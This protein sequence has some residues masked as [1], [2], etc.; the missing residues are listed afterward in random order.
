MIH[1]FTIATRAYNMTAFFV[2]MLAVNSDGE[3]FMNE[4]PFEPYITDARMNSRGNVA[5][6]VFDADYPTYLQSQFPDSYQDMLE[7]IPDELQER[8]DDGEVFRADT[9]EEL[10]GMIG[11]PADALARTAEK[12]NEMYEQGADTQFGVVPRMLCQVKTAPFYAVPIHA[13]C[14]AM[15]FG[16]Y[17][18]EDSQVCTDDEPIAG[19][20]AAGNCQGDF[21]AFNY[22]VHCPGCS[23]GRSLV[24]GQLIGEALA[25]GQ[26]ITQLVASR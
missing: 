26:T 22:P 5:W 7:T 12:Y 14:L 2:T 23:T 17:V 21:F 16:L 4:M 20:F 24:F 11:V 25:K 10:A 6:S 1:Q 3:R 18:N 19:L 8:I 9:L 13:S 15:P